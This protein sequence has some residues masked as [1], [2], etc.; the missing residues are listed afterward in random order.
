M[1]QRGYTLVSQQIRDKI[2]QYELHTDAT[3]IK[4]DDKGHFV[5]KNLEARIQPA[6]YDLTLS[7]EL[8]ILDAETAGIF[9]PTKETTVKEAIFQLPASQRQQINIDKDKGFEIRKGFFYLIRLVEKIRM[10]ENEDAE[11]S[12]K[13]TFGRLFLDTRMIADYNPCFNK[14]KSCYKKD[15]PLELWLLVHPQAFNTTIY[16]GISL[17]QLRFFEGIGAQLTPT[18]LLYEFKQNPLL[19][20]RNDDGNLQPATLDEHI[21]TDGG[22]QIHL[23]ALG[24]HTHSIVG[25][26]T[27]HTP[28]S[29]DTKKLKGHYAEEYHR[30]VFKEKPL[31]EPD[32]AYLLFS[33]ECI[34]VPPHL[35][36]QL[37]S[38]SDIGL[39]A[40]LHDAGFFDNGF[41]AD[42]VFEIQSN[43]QVSTNFYHGMPIGVMDFFRTIM[44]PDK[45]YGT[46]IGSNYQGQV[47]SKVAKYFTDFDFKKAR[48]E[49]TVS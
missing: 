16:P 38:R 4:L 21:I 22:L 14:I 11:S 2:A 23:D 3:T 28:A 47:G 1:Q 6:G 17:N 9:R 31:I 42:C 7:T 10:S 29:V 27:K 39:N 48:E 20:H 25:L 30:A 34:R 43:E 36:G 32:Q 15:K 33:K 5:D 18:E 13:S 26:K 8:Y 41:F 49:Y 37:K 40:K 12:P 24:R 44:T 45:I 19:Y 46:T 35:C